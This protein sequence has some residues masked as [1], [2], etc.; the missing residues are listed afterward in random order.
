MAGGVNT[1]SSMTASVE[2]AVDIGAEEG[3]AHGPPGTGI[4]GRGH[5]RAATRRLHSFCVRTGFRT[6]DGITEIMDRI[7]VDPD[8]AAGG[9]EISGRR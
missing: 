7:T 2:Q 9:V 6:E 8:G 4:A 5:R 3:S 1:E